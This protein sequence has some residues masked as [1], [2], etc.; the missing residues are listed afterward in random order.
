MKTLNKFTSVKF[1]ENCVKYGI[2]A[3]KID[4]VNDPYEGVGIEN[5]DLFRIVC[6]TN[7]VSQMLMWAYYGNHHGCRIEYDVSVIPEYIMHDVQYVDDFQDHSDMTPKEIIQSLYKKG[8]EWK[9][10]QEV[11][12]V[13]YKPYADQMLWTNVGNDIY[14]KAPVVSVMFGLLAGKGN[15]AEV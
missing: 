6:L 11:R 7:A 9:K 8:S 4:Q 14:L 13:Y 10:E 15:D 5:P 2:Y 12:A 1:I 3:S